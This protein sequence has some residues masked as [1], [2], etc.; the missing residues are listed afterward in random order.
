MSGIMLVCLR[1]AKMDRKI[2]IDE[3]PGNETN[4]DWIAV[5]PN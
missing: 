1:R 5:R 4:L 2:F 3:F